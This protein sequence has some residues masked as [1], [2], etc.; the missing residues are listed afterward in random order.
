MD[1]SVYF[2]CK[3]LDVCAF[4]FS[5]GRPCHVLRI[6]RHT[7]TCKINKNTPVF[8]LHASTLIVITLLIFFVTFFNWV[9]IFFHHFL[10][11]NT[12]SILITVLTIL[13]TDGYWLFLFLVT[14]FSL[15]SLKRSY[16]LKFVILKQKQNPFWILQ[17]PR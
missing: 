6:L 2:T 12:L 11:N 1:K 15:H 9:F 4:H 10:F 8:W 7:F 13:N 14:L 5:S 17:G 3:K 16:H